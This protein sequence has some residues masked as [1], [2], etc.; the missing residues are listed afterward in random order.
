MILVMTTFHMEPSDH[1]GRSATLFK[2]SHPRWASARY[3]R[4]KWG[5]TI[6]GVWKG[7]KLQPYV[8]NDEKLGMSVRDDPKLENWKLNDKSVVTGFRYVKS[9][10]T[11]IGPTCIYEN[12]PTEDVDKG[13]ANHKT[14]RVVPKDAKL[15]CTVYRPGRRQNM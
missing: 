6:I 1:R 12:Q 15:G 14:T 8:Q 4:L 10:C 3:R 13:D 5:I 11:Q 7:G 9:L 2:Y